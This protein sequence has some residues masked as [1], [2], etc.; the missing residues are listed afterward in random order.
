MEAKKWSALGLGALLLVGYNA[1]QPDLIAMRT[2]EENYPGTKRA[3]RYGPSLVWLDRLMAGQSGSSVYAK[4]TQLNFNVLSSMMVA[5]LASGFKSQVANLLWM[6]SDEY[7]HKGLL[8]RQVPLMEAVVT[9]DPQF[10][11]AWSTAGWHWAYNIYADLPE[12]PDLKKLGKD[13]KQLRLEQERCVNIGL[14]YLKRGSNLNPETYRLWF[15]NAWTR[16]EKAGIYDDET[17]RLMRTARAQKD[18]RQLERTVA[19]AN[20]KSKTEEVLGEDLVGRNIGHIYEKMPDIDKALDE[21]MTLIVNGGL[22]KQYPMGNIENGVATSGTVGSVGSVIVLSKEQKQQF[23]KIGCSDWDIVQIAE[24]YVKAKPDARAIVKAAIP[25]IDDVL[26][27]A[28]EIRALRPELTAAGRYW[29]LYGRDYD[30]IAGIYRDNDAVVRAQ[31][32]KLVPDVEKLLEAQKARETAQAFE[33]QA[34]GA[35]VSITARYVPTWQQMKRGDLAGAVSTIIGVMNADGIHHVQKMPVMAKIFELRGDA[36]EVI[37]NSLTAAKQFENDS[38]Q[39]I[40]LHLLA[41]LYEA[42]RLKAVGT[43][44]EKVFAHK[45]Y[46]TWYRGRERNTLDFYSRRN[47]FLLEDKYGFTPPQNIINEIKKARRSGSGVNAAPA[48]PNVAQYQNQ[49]A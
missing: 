19:E 5:G 27:R 42:E 14:D 32:K 2:T 40:G 35:F 33:A 8:T 34:T 24:F 29:G 30:Q 28:D 17:V 6:K 16:G 48:P 47:T 44:Q 23:E 31:I 36:P 11:E 15:E 45:E 46:E 39:E 26:K 25:Q 9:L 4:E 38:S 1:S 21:Y 3:E 20:G 37:R 10:I 12:R 13:S 41:K 7:W 43:P 18:A 22:R 49:Q